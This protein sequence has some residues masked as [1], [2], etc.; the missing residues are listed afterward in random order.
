MKK[1][2]IIC[3]CLLCALSLSAQD[4]TYW[5]NEVPENWNGKWPKE[6]MTKTEL[7]SFAHTAN[8]ND[9]LEYFSQIV[10]E[11]EYVHVFNMFTSDLGRTSPTLVMSNPRVTSAEEAKKTGKTIIYLQGGIHPSE[12]EGKEAL[13]MVIRDILFGDKKYLLDELIILINPNFNVDGNE[14]RV[15]NNGNPRLTGTR[16]NGA[17]YDVNRDGIKLQTKNMRGA[18]KNVLN[19]WDPILIYDTHRMGDTRHGYA[20]AQAGSNVVTAHSS[21]RDYVTYKIFPEIV[22]KAREKSKIEVGMHCGLNQGWPPT[23]FTH[24]NSIWSTEAKFMVN[25]Y[26]LRNRMAILVETPGGEAFEKAIYSSYAYTNALLE[27]CYE[28][29][30]EMQEICHNAEKE[31]VQLIKDK[32]ASGNL[33][34][35]VSGKYILEGNITM[36]AYRNTKTK[37]IPGTS[38][39][40]LDRP[41][42]PEWIDNVTLIT[43]P[44]G[45][46]EAK[47]PRGYLIPEQFKHLADKLKLHGVQVKQLKHDFTIS[48]ESY[49]IDKM[50]YK[51]MGFANYQMTTLHGEYVDVSNK[52]IPAGTYE[53]DMAQPLA[54]LIFYALEPQVRDGFIGWNLLDKE[55]VEMGVN[56][57]PVLLPIVKYYSKK[58]N[59]K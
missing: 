52:K 22:K 39:E 12:C 17:G 44:I 1:T 32:A 28:H 34:N 46:Q 33:T 19:T 9:I 56:Q 29:G 48:G 54:N 58:T 8:Y 6:L 16:R 11:S 23:E 53:I 42:P 7:S 26:G 2:W 38:I 37:T 27:Y 13:L 45:V 20:I 50:E 55:L 47:V 49:L 41:N 35:Y 36:P 3:C 40:E 15:V 5:G 31:V 57:K 21:P 51:P 24:D 43:K 59:F 18:L 25:A 30:K 10:W 4:K 14:A